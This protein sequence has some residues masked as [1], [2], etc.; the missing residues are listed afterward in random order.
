MLSNS[1]VICVLNLDVM[2]SENANPAP[3]IEGREMND[4]PVVSHDCPTIKVDLKLPNRAYPER[5][6]IA[7]S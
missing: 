3:A 2:K 7:A 5:L 1:R 4:I 6:Y